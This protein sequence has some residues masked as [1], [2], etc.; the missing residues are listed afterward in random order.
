MQDESDPTGPDDS[1]AFRELFLRHPQPMWIFDLESLRILAV[2]QAAIADFGYSHDEFLAMTIMDLRPE[3]DRPAFA[4][5]LSEVPKAPVRDGGTW[6]HR[7]KDGR[8]IH[9]EVTVHTLTF[10]DRPAR[11]VMSRNVTD[12]ILAEARVRRA[13]NLL[14]I[15][16]QAAHLGGWIMD[17]QTRRLEFSDE[18]CAIH[19]LPAGCSPTLEE[20]LAFYAPGSR[21]RISELFAACAAEGTPYH[22]ELELIT[23]R[24]RRLWVLTIGE[25]VRAADG[26]IVQIQGAFQDITERKREQI[27]Q[28]SEA[29]VLKLISSQAPLP[30]ILERIVLAI[31]S[32]SAGGM[33]SIV[34][35]DPDSLR[36]RVAAAPHLPAAFLEKVDGSTIGPTAGSCGTAMY[37]RAPVAVSDIASD[38]LWADRRDLAAQ[39]GLRACWATPVIS[40]TGEV[41]ASFALYFRDVR[42]P[43][44]G[45]RALAER[46]GSLAAMAIDQS[47]TLRSLQAAEERFRQLAEN[48]GEVFWIREKSGRV[49]YVSPAFES[50]WG[51]SC[52]SLY[53]DQTQ[54][55]A[56]IHDGDRT[57]V[58]ANLERPIDEPYVAEY[59]IVRP[60]GEIRWI[61]DRGF[62]VLNAD[63][64]VYRVAGTARDVT[65]QKQ[66]ENSL[67]DSEL[68]FQSVARASADVLWDLD[69][70]SG[71]I[72]WS[73]D[74][75]TRFGYTVEEMEPGLDAWAEKV[76]PDDRD[77]VVASLHA[78]VEH[79]DPIWSSEYRFL[80]R[81]GRVLEVQDN[82]C[83]IL[84][85]DG[86]PIR[87][88]GGVLD[89]TD[90]NR[91]QRELR[92]RIK[93]LHCLYRVL[94][95]TGHDER[96]VAEICADIARTL[97]DALLHDTKAVARLVLDGEEYCSA[98]WQAP[99]VVLCA[100]IRSGGTALGM[101]EIGYREARAEEGQGQGPFLPDERALVDAAAAHVGRM[102]D[103]R[104]MT[105]RLTQSER[106]R[107]VGE[108]TGGIAHDFN[109]LLQVIL[110]NAEL[111]EEALAEQPRL[112]NLADLTRTAAL[113][114]ADL[115][116]RL[117]AFSRR[118]ALEPKATDV[119]ALLAGMDELLRRTLGE[120]ISITTTSVS[121]LW[122]INVDRPQLE[123]AVL[124]LCI[125]ARDAMPGGG[126]LTIEMANLWLDQSYV[127]WNEEVV[128]GP[129][130][131]VAISDT[132]IGMDADTVSRAF[133]PF[134]T[135]KEVGR[136]SGLGLS[137]VFGFVKQSKGHVTLYSE[138]GQGTTVRLYLPRA[139]G[140]AQQPAATEAEAPVAQGQERILLVEDDDLVRT[141][142]EAQLQALGYHV[143]SVADGPSA[144]AALHQEQ[145]FDL[146]FTDVVMS[147]G[148]SG[149][150]LAQQATRLRPGL[151]VLFTSGYTENTIIHH[152]GLDAD[153]HL[154]QKP[155]RRQDLAAMVRRVLEQTPGPA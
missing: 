72:W 52:D 38:P 151:P 132:G 150:A 14:R 144:L 135:T 92:E 56:A 104:R 46:A 83:L 41:L 21:E 39:H 47:R 23:A 134:F 22:E 18:V 60:D 1:F 76:H 113:R 101:V 98:D 96:P 87:L 16:G 31:E 66:V 37:R 13:E 40:A 33:G 26:G 109:N 28:A 43:G 67:R 99:A 129:Y 62:P 70:A 8:L 10:R 102:L 48:V 7:L 124:N 142:V 119:A 117:L 138:P 116:G 59:R 127:H 29:E 86:S 155:Y 49:I 51:R 125:N 54:W 131:M 35:L 32:L 121:D 69:L 58:L 114:G 82:G 71:R 136:G 2:N 120:H 12:R 17:V 24:G 152:G 19:D 81:D 137:M 139:E 73:E 88:I 44:D 85:Q 133:E 50:I 103:N 64:E 79:R 105:D 25:A 149:P 95:L 27:L 20:A 111:L 45:D 91:S 34:L 78:A 100:P 6:R 11:L 112:K 123:N 122:Q 128:P 145:S 97:P 80:H 147:G 153:V 110:G 3:D 141:H 74:F 84:G 108:L 65:E 61:A 148:I 55:L 68:R 53:Q 118:Q 89:I 154:L 146:L 106:L 77:R 140:D 5:H 63:G 57:E 30:Q 75:E 15:A 130:V 94:E 42:S 143:L 4:R 90:R 115:T 9:A 126:R 93:E 36:L 107:A